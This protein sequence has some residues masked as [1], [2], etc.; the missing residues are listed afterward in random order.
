MNKLARVYINE[1]VT[2]HGVPLSIISDRDSDFMLWF[3]RLLHHALGTRLDMSTV[4]HP[5]MDGQ[6]ERMIQMMEDMLRACVIDFGDR[7]LIRLDIIQETVDKITAIKERLRTAR[8]RQ[9]SY[10]DNRRKPL[11]F[12]IGDNVLLNVPPI[13]G[14]IRF[15]K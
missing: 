10:A 2:R 9:K 8:S 4:Y 5:Q 12:Q 1:I 3:W 6:S 13:E 14:M 11:K 7:Q 15:R